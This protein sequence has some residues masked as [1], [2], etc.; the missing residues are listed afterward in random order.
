MMMMRIK[1]MMT[2]MIIEDVNNDSDSEDDSD[3][4]ETNT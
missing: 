1:R 2:I 3:C 4:Y